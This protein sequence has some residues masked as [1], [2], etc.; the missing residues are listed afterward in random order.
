MWESPLFSASAPAGGAS[1]ASQP[2]EAG[3]FAW[4]SVDHAARGAC[5]R[6]DPAAVL[7][8]PRERMI[9]TKVPKGRHARADDVG[10]EVV[11]SEVR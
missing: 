6:A 8:T 11:E 7:A 5:T 9:E 10:Q 4:P 3:S 2:P 1:V